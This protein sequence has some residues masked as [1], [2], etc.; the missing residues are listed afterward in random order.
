MAP[1]VF[2]SDS[3]NSPRVN[4]AKIE[5]IGAAENLGD[6]GNSIISTTE[7]AS[8]EVGAWIGRC[9]DFGGTGQAIKQPDSDKIASGN[10]HIQ[11]RLQRICLFFPKLKS[12]LKLL[13]LLRK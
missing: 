1:I 9:S 10:R 11:V 6:S 7:E 3:T 12:K 13:K 5:A 8:D 4:D 2:R